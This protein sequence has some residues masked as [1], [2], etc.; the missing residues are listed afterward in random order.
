MRGAIKFLL[1]LALWTLAAPLAMALRIEGLPPSYWE[2]TWVYALLGIPVKALLIALFGL[3]RQ[4][5]R[6]V[7]VRD[8]VQ[9][10]TAVGL[11][12]AVLLA[13]AVVLRAYLPMP[14]SVPLIAM[15]LAFLLLGGVRL[16][17]RLYW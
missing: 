2:T 4:A 9:L 3:H 6:R 16:G 10:G 12:G 17:V 13:F 7:G 14:R 8:L 15:V 5:W 1:D 11:G